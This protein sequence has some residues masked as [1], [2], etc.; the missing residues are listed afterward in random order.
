MHAT[1]FVELNGIPIMGL[2]YRDIPPR[3]E[4]LPQMC[5]HTL[6]IV[7][8]S[9][10]SGIWSIG[11]K[12]YD[13]APG[14]FF[15]F[16][17]NEFRAI[18]TIYPPENLHLTIIDFEPRFIWSNHGDLFD[19]GY[20]KIFFN[21]NNEI[22]KNRIPGGTTISSQ[23]KSVISEMEA[24][25]LAKP[26]MY[27][28]M[29]KVKLLNILTLLNRYY[30]D[31]MGIEDHL[32]TSFNHFGIVSEVLKYI[33]EHMNEDVSRELLAKLVH[34]HPTSLSKLFKKYNGIG[35]TQYII[36]KKIHH[37][38]CLLEQSNLSVLEISSLSGFNNVTN[39][40]K[41]FKTV[42]GTVPL[43]YRKKSQ[44]NLQNK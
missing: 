29:L 19:S 12:S 30:I 17:N 21:R 2:C 28:Q 34:M 22:F 11:C 27:K 35:L 38:T 37:A 44:F 15:I 43:S 20:L 7:Y 42:T 1:E 33:D 18:R 32:S 16:N 24:E 3:Q 13:I 31:S 9:Q 39:F 14:D 26:P 40:Y 23:L 25:L 5:Y 41:A 4:N 10:G 36:R 6:K 8:V